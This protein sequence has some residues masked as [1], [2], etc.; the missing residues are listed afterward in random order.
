MFHTYNK[1]IMKEEE[2]E[3]YLETHYQV[4]S[5][6]EYI[7]LGNYPSSEKLQEYRSENGMGGM[8]G[9]WMLAKAI[10]DDF[11][12]LHRGREWD[13]EWLEELEKYVHFRI[14]QL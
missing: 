14:D 11:Q 4:V 3:D 2:L 10:T 5:E 12:T 8:G 7:A 13:G 9:M 6:I 1:E